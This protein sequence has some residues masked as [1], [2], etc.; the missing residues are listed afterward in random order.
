M[1]SKGAWKWFYIYRKKK[2]DVGVKSL[3][4]KDKEH[5]YWMLGKLKVTY[6]YH[7]IVKEKHRYWMLG[8]LKSNIYITEGWRKN[9]WFLFLCSFSYS[10]S[11]LSAEFDV[12][13]F[14]CIFPPAAKTELKME[15][16]WCIIHNTKR[17][18]G[19][20]LGLSLLRNWSEVICNSNIGVQVDKI[21]IDQYSI[22]LSNVTQIGSFGL[23][24]KVLLEFD[25]FVI[26]IIRL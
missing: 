6:L 16:L 4:N 14:H 9:E 2:Q 19:G 23:T 1:L 17:W 24:K 15:V 12:S 5:G 20:N 3:V 8:K 13:T 21:S 7:W 26:I 18:T 11:L 10:F 22:P 25:Y